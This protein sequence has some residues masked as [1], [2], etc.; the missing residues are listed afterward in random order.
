MYLYVH[1]YIYVCVYMSVCTIYVHALTLYIYMY[2]CLRVYVLTGRS[3]D[4]VKDM[5]LG[6]PASTVNILIGPTPPSSAV[7]LSPVDK[8]KMASTLQHSATHCNALQH[9][10]PEHSVISLARTYATHSHACMRACSSRTRCA[11]LADVC[12]KCALGAPGLGICNMICMPIYDML[13]HT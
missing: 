8:S 10:T 1:I 11:A 4:E 2:V 3:T 5:L 12:A 7:S 13:C 9:L 6:P